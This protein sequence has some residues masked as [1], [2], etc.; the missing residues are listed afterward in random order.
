MNRK[1]FLKREEWKWMR[2]ILELNTFVE[3]KERG[4]YRKTT[5][6]GPKQREDKAYTQV[7][8][9]L[10]KNKPIKPS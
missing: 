10:I 7:I 5:V 1:V 8:K 2:A 4:S 9:K 3:D 6:V